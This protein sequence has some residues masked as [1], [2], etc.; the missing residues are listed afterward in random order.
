MR[1]RTEADAR[2]FAET[3]FVLIIEQGLPGPE[4]GRAAT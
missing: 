2:W 3:V 1:L 4:H